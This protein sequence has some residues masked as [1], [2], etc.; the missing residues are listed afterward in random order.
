MKSLRKKSTRKSTRKSIRKSI[1]KKPKSSIKKNMD[2]GSKK[3][4]VDTDKHKLW[5]T[6]YYSKALQ[7]GDCLYSS[8]FR[9]LRDKE[10][11]FDFPTLEN[12]F[13]QKLRN[14]TAELLTLEIL[15]TN[16]KIILESETTK[17]DEILPF[18]KQMADKLFANTSLKNYWEIRSI[19]TSKY[20]PFKEQFDDE[21]FLNDLL[22]DVKKNIKIMRTYSTSL[23]INLINDWLK[24]NY[25]PAPFIEVLTTRAKVP[26]DWKIDDNNIYIININLSNPKSDIGDHYDYFIDKESIQ[27]KKQLEEKRRKQAE[28]K[29]Q[30]EEKKL[31]E[32][33]KKMKI[34]L[35]KAR[36]LEEK[37][38]LEMEKL[39][40]K[41]IIEAEKKGIIEKEKKE[42][43]KTLR[44]VNSLKEELKKQKA[45]ELVEKKRRE[46]EKRRLE[47]ER[48]EE[49]KKQK[50]REL[51]EKKRREME[52]RRIKKIIETEKKRIIEK[53]KKEEK[54][55][56][57]FVNSLKEE[58]K[59]LLKTSKDKNVYEKI[60]NTYNQIISLRQKHYP[61]L[62]TFYKQQYPYA[63]KETELTFE[64]QNL[65]NKLGT[66]VDDDEIIKRMEQIYNEMMKN[67]NNKIRI[68]HEKYNSEVDK[69][70]EKN[71]RKLEKLALGEK[72][73]EEEYEMDE[74]QR[75]MVELQRQMDDD[76]GEEY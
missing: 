26:K 43:K 16:V 62:S 63:K 55:H 38:N 11:L 17:G 21:S 3:Q 37:K 73:N 24:L 8:V 69:L 50:A 23:E 40:M 71:K 14:E 5:I 10:L 6:K 9:T 59:K 72:F 64:K 2:G 28:L 32:L 12:E 39:R 52:K 22:N 29:K 65:I 19:Y 27:E 67:I 54:E 33:E 30:L 1:R 41:K 49:L 60:F 61:F 75:E 68:P 53:E 57:T 51:Q 13:I 74:L 76:M 20:N 35:K 58:L 70:S 44:F 45:Q 34:N 18:T 56:L 25:S 66:N 47:K 7:N 46:M 48:Q 31:K 4:D 36:E 15:N 42:E